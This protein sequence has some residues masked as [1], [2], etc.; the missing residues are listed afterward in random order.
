M[1]FKVYNHG[2]KYSYLLHEI[3]F[4][5]FQFGTTIGYSAMYSEMGRRVGRGQKNKQ[6]WL[7]K[8]IYS[9]IYLPMQKASHLF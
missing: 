6:M 5:D 4:V 9:P 2:S 8:I 3:G 1:T 7:P